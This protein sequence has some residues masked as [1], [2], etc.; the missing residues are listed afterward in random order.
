M[1]TLQACKDEIAQLKGFK[2]RDEM[3]AKANWMEKDANEAAE[4]YAKSAK[5]E[6]WEESQQSIIEA[7]QDSIIV[8]GLSLKTIPNPY[9]S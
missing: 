7:N 6:A 1:K 4:L 5:A 2:N 8:N 3:G 9:K